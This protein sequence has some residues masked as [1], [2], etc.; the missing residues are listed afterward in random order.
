MSQ[1]TNAKTLRNQSSDQLIRLVKD[2]K[3]E[4]DSSYGL[5]AKRQKQAE[6]QGKLL[7]RFDPHNRFRKRVI[8]RCL[9]IL[10]ERGI[11]M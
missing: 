11:K 10:N 7:P 1:Q 5:M 3:L 9:T 2:M 8:A 4:I 6:V